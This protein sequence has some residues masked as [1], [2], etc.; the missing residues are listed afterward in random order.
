MSVQNVKV[1][2]IRP[3]GYHN[4]KEWIADPKNTY[5]GRSGVVF[6]D[7]ERFPKQSSVFAN[8]YKI[9]KHGSREDVVKRYESY[10]REKLEKDSDLQKK[11]LELDGQTLGCWCHPEACHGDVLLRLIDEYRK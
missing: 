8:P 11:L 5:I 1:K 7:K 2:F 4:L 3:L 10:I 9:S 6:V